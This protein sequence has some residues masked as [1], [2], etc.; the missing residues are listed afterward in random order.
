M[1]PERLAR[2]VAVLE[3]APLEVGLV[4]SGLRMVDR[5]GEEVALIHT[6]PGS[7]PSGWVFP[8][9]LALPVI[10]TPSVLVRREV[11]DTVGGFHEGDP[12][13]DYDMWLRV[14]R[15]YEVRHVPE[16]LVNFRWHGGNTTT[17]VQGEVYETYVAT[18]LR[19]QLGYAPDTDEVIRRRLAEM[20]ASLDG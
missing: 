16:P 3:E 6:D 4:Y 10:P 15:E 11:Y 5:D 2:Q 1:E 12:L 8:Q 13:E 17:R 14:C 20:G 19:R 18:C 9:Q 7:A